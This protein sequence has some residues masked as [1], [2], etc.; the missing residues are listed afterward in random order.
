MSVGPALE[1]VPWVPDIAISLLTDFPAH[2][3]H[4]RNMKLT[5]TL[6]NLFRPS[7]APV[8]IT[9]SSLLR[10][11]TRTTWMYTTKSPP[12]R[13]TS[14]EMTVRYSGCSLM[15]TGFPWPTISD[16]VSMD[17]AYDSQE[18]DPAPR[19]LPGTRKGVLEKIETWV[20][21]GSGG[22][23]VLWVHGPAGAGK[24]AI[25][26]TVAETCASTKLLLCSHC[27]HPGYSQTPLSHYSR[28]DRLIITRKTP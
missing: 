21:A 28:L 17:A 20:K 19:C 1:A 13:V 27:C 8:T 5:N 6:K 2:P 11:L 7:A 26:Q 23:S 9:G 10:M 18:R 12:T 15:T 22:K 24:S 3:E 4:T 16:C 25:A 14:A